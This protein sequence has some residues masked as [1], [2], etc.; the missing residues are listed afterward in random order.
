MHVADCSDLE[1]EIM[2]WT[3]DHMNSGISVFTK[4]TTFEVRKWVV[5][6][7]ITVLVETVSWYYSCM[8]RQGL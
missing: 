1:V 7:G 4:M 3:I 2:N 6:Y 5:T 8:K